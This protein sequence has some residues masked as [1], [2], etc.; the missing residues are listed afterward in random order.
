M[1]STI[2]WRQESLSCSALYMAANSSS[3]AAFFRVTDKNKASSLNGISEK[4]TQIFAAVSKNI[5]LIFFS[6]YVK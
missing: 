4:T 1:F 2:N 3:S 6:V 5:I